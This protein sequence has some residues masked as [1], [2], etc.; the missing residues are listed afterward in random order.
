MY[1]SEIFFPKND[2][3]GASWIK[4]AADEGDW[5]AQRLIAL[6][7]ATGRGVPVDQQE[8]A[9]Y[10]ALAAKNPNTVSDG[11]GQDVIREIGPAK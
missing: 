3:E 9:R 1:M 6:M 4:R 8:S 5:R 11:N 10:A 2:A 7:F